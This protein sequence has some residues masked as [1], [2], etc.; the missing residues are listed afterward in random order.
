MTKLTVH[1]NNRC[2][3]I[4]FH[5]VH[6]YITP[7]NIMTNIPNF[8]CLLSTINM[9]PTSLV[10]WTILLTMI[11]PTYPALQQ[12]STITSSLLLSRLQPMLL[13]NY[14]ELLVRNHIFFLACFLKSSPLWW[15]FP[16]KFLISFQVTLRLDFVL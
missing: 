15:P 9:R 13:L 11:F 1:I 7:R 2:L 10:Q 16:F 6:N 3:V 4:H 5:V 12:S 8:L 14:V